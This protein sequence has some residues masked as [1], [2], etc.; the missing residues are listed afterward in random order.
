M[1]RIWFGAAAVAAAMTLASLTPAHAGIGLEG[2]PGYQHVGVLLLE[3]E[4]ESSTWGASSVAKYLNSLVSAGAFASDYYAD[5]H[6]SLDNYITLSS[7]LPGNPNTYGDCLGISLNACQQTITAQQTAASAAASTNTMNVGDQVEGAGL[8]WKEYADGTSSPCFHEDLSSTS[9]DPYQGDTNM[10]PGYNYADRHNP[11][12]YYT[13][14]TGNATR[15]NA[16]DVP[17]TQLSTDITNDS[18]PNFFF[19]TPD[20]CHDG[21]DAPCANGSAMPAFCSTGAGGPAQSA[22]VGGLTAADCWLQANLP[23]LLQYLYAHDGVLFITTDE[24][25]ANPPDTSGCCTGGQGGQMGV[26]GKVGLLALGPGVKTNFT[27]TNNYDHVSLL[28]TVEDALGISTHINN[29][30]TATAMSD[31]FAQPST[32]TPETPL[33]IALPLLGVGLAAAF[34]RR[35]RTGAG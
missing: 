6:V 19:I 17:F 31:L 5:G 16:V 35:R 22:A 10:A 15:C 32:S 24:G 21:H 30:A 33:A 18:V 3:N 8:T 20:T 13:D 23:S 34:V 14:I 2:V 4:S 1:R 11:F 28:R 7:G 27:S 12:V 26:G 29:A 25:S 9:S